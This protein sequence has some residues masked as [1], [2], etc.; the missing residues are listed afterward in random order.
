[1]PLS[2]KFKALLLGLL[3]APTLCAQLL[4]QQS[5][6]NSVA[7]EYELDR[8]TRVIEAS[9]APAEQVARALFD[10]GV[11]FARAEQRRSAIADFTRVAAMSDAPPATVADALFNRAIMFSELGLPQREIDDYTLVIGLEGASPET[12]A[13]ALYNRAITYAQL[14]QLHAAVG[15]FEAVT[16]L[17]DVSEEMLDKAK[18]LLETAR[19][20]LSE[21]SE[22][23]H[24]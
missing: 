10:R 23:S 22:M 11:I 15:D 7:V 9:D 17:S 20:R 12:L 14:G 8:Y 18:T 24:A 4:A 13:S 16:R 1:M 5:A 6:G 3:L 2:W 21:M 19:L